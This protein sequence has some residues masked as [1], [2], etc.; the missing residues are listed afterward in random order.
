MENTIQAANQAPS[1]PVA[2]K[3]V[4][5][6][7]GIDQVSSTQVAAEMAQTKTQASEVIASSAEEIKQAVESLRVNVQR[8]ESALKISINDAVDIPIITVF[9]ETSNKVIRQI[10]NEEVVALANFMA[11]QNFDDYGSKNDALG[12]LLNKQV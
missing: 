10:P 4:P 8:V 1:Q 7:R 2:P 12:M 6:A 11:S 5:E 3:P 9:D